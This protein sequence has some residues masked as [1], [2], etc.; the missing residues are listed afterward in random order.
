MHQLK[1]RLFLGL[2]KMLESFSFYQR[3]RNAV[4]VLFRLLRFQITEARMAYGH[5]SSRENNA[6]M[7][8]QMLPDIHL[9][10][11]IGPPCTLLTVLGMLK[12][13]EGI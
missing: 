4:L 12:V 10:C 5:F 9:N 11:R 7:Y 8:R 3:Y 13:Y 1:Q 2:D 6:G